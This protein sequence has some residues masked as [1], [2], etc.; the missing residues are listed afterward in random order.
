M[1]TGAVRGTLKGHSSLVKAVA[2][3]LDGQLVASGS[4]D[5]TVRLWDTATGAV[6]GML[7]VHASIGNL[8]F[9]RDGQYLETDRGSICL[10][11]LPPDASRSQAQSL[12]NIFVEG[13]WITR[14]TDNF[15]WLP[16][17]YRAT[18]AA[19]HRNLLALG[20]ESGQVT[21]IEFSS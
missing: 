15:L 4:E 11:L 5:M 8:S 2:F 16:S 12:C 1:A 21:F 9:S 20:H 14:D 17:D 7:E 19:L 10:R 13:D 6:R 18:C 3:S